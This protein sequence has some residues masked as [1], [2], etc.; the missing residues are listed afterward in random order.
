MFYVNI[1]QKTAGRAVLMLYRVDFKAKLPE[2]GK[3][4]V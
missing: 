1:N 4:I 2:S 3:G